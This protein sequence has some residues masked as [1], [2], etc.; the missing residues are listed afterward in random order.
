MY[1]FP[2]ELV[3]SYLKAYF[4][5]KKTNKNI[6]NMSRKKSTSVVIKIHFKYQGTA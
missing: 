1:V 3:Y 5:R 4:T 2:L 6:R